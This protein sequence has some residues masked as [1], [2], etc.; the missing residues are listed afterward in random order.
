MD[1]IYVQIQIHAAGIDLNKK[2]F[3]TI[4]FSKKVNILLQYKNGDF[5]LNF[6]PQL[7]S[8][9]TRLEIKLDLF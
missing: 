7:S 8:A 3:K 5:T 1:Q 9:S 6:Y 2:N 4:C